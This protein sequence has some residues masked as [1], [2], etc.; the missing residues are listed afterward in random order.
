MDLL[1]EI[2]RKEPLDDYL[3]CAA[4]LLT[5]FE[6]FKRDF[7]VQL[8]DDYCFYKQLDIEAG[9]LTEGDYKEYLPVTKPSDV[10]NVL[11]PYRL[12]L[13]HNIDKEHGNAHVLIDV[14]WP[15]PHFFQV[16]MQLTPNSWQH[17]HTELVG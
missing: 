2:P 11:T 6:E 8:H 5:R 14:Y 16:F 10:W 13:G 15:N 4:N 3:Q 7:T 17:M 12:W 9:G 1:I